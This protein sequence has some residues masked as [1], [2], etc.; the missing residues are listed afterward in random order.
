MIDDAC[1]VDKKLPFALLPLDSFPTAEERKNMITNREKKVL[2]LLDVAEARMSDCDSR[3]RERKI[4][5]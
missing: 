2:S 1:G 5:N 4:R 3:E